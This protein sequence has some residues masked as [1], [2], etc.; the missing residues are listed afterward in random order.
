MK[1]K[2]PYPP[3]LPVCRLSGFSTFVWQIQLLSAGLKA[4]HHKTLHAKF[5]IGLPLIIFVQGALLTYLLM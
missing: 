3:L 5:R 2:V 4:F 1:S